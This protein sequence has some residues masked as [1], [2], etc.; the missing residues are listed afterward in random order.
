MQ[1]AFPM[2]KATT[3]LDELCKLIN[4]NTPA[5]LVEMPNGNHHIVTRYDVISSMS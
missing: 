4:K 5:A 1:E 3:H 2:V